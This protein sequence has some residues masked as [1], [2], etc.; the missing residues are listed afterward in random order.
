MTLPDL[1]NAEFPAVAFEHIDGKDVPK[2]SERRE[3]MEEVQPTSTV[4]KLPRMQVKEEYVE[5]YR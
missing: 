1:T 2:N 4:C 3:V 5:V